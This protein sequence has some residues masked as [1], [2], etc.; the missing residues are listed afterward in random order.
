MAPLVGHRLRPQHQTNKAAG[1]IMELSTVV[2]IISGAL[3]LV[4]FV[5]LAYRMKNNAVR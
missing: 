3:A 2:R 5:V 4:V 1:G